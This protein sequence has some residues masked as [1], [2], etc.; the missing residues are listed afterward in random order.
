MH[1]M[2]SS[3]LS[4]ALVLFAAEPAEHKVI[5]LYPGPAP[6]SKGKEAEDKPTL[7]IYLPPA[8]KAT[9]AAVVICPGGGYGFLANDHEGKQPAEWLNKLGVAA[10]IL[11]Y[12]IVTK[13]RFA[14]LLDAP[15]QDAQ[16]AIRTVR[17]HAKEYGVDPKR[18]AIWGFSAGGHLAS[19]AATHFDDGKADAGDPIE[20]VGCRPDFAILC[21]PVVTMKEGT[22]GGSRYNLLGAKPDDKLI[23]F[24]S[25]E[26]QVTAKTPPTFIFQTDEDKAV[27]AENS[28]QFYLA[29]RKAHVP[30]EMHI[31][32][33]GAHGVGLAP[34]DPVLSTWP[35]L[36][37]T[38]MKQ[39]GLLKASAK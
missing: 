35:D 3:V 4:L 5:D 10:F 37:A 32:E 39:Q 29:C 34:K 16:R 27:P 20:R 17:A 38:W 19:T 33:K 2:N 23:E 12:R 14:P 22:H 6:G 8:E 9:G 13:D 11:K 7:T 24:Y 1:A 15:L 25:N 36:L 31:Y 18:I 30:A 28:V 21:Y 26:R